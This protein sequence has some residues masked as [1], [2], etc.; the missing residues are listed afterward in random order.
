M[1]WREEAPLADRNGKENHGREEEGVG[2]RTWRGKM[3]Q[4][5]GQEDC[6]RGKFPPQSKGKADASEGRPEKGGT[7]F[8]SLAH[9]GSKC[10]VSKV[11]EDVSSFS[12]ATESAR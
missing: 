8:L 4:A 6:A 3:L 2:E 7:G 1:L 11:G 5:R 9:S 10:Q 12:A